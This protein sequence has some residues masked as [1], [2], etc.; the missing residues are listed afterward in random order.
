MMT[1][2]YVHEQTEL[3][4]HLL[5]TILF[6][7]ASGEFDLQQYRFTGNALELQLKLMQMIDALQFQEADDL[8]H[9]AMDQDQ[10]QESLQIGVW[11]YDTLNHI[12]GDVLEENG[13][14]TDAVLEGMQHLE[15]FVMG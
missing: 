1:D 10:G 6:P 14:S 13:F 5:R 8:L 9:Q 15:R 3:L 2:E 4:S 11:F 12:S 7:Q